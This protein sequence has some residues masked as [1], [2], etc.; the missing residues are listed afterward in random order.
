MMMMMM[1]SANLVVDE[2]ADPGAV[3][4]L[5]ASRSEHK[6][7]AKLA[8]INGESVA[9]TALFR[10][11]VVTIE[12]RRGRR[13]TSTTVTGSATNLNLDIRLLQ[14]PQTKLG[15]VDELGQFKGHHTG[16]H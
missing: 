6:V 16:Q 5:E 2:S 1:M 7:P 15:H 8:E 12:V 14:R 11:G 9:A 3:V 13:P 4:R 10:R